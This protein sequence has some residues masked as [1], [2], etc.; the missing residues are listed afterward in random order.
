MKQK[1]LIIIDVSFTERDYKRFGIDILK[2]KFDVF[3]FD[4]TKNFIKKSATHKY[5]QNPYKFSGYYD[6]KNISTFVE[7]LDKHKFSNCI[8]YVSNKPLQHKLIDILK[9]NKIPIIKIQHGLFVEPGDLRTFIQKFHI[10]ILKFTNKKMFLVFIKNQIINLRKRF[11]RKVPNIFYDKVIV[12]GKVGLKRPAISLNT[13]VI[14]AHTYDYDNYLDIK[15][16]PKSGI[17]KP[18]AV[19]ID[20]YLPL[21]PD[22][23]I[24]FGV[25]PR[26][27]VE[28]YYPALNNFF[29]IFEK[30]YNMNIIVS[31]HPKSDY[32]SNPK[33]LYGRKFVRNKTISLIRDCEVVFSHCSAAISYAILLKKPI[34][35]LLSNEYI[36]SF[37][38]Y[39]PA[40]LAKKLNSLYFNID[41]KNNNSKIKNINLFKVDNKKYK[42]YK[43]DY[44]KYPSSI[45]KKFWKIFNE[46]I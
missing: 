39:T 45:N 22:A 40:V 11:I 41:D 30:E 21:H 33:F 31:A 43:D 12:T 15:K 17:K 2:K 8:D 19:F 1:I 5:F 42:I 16:I 9:I 44:I 10:L 3:V 18:Y 29:N 20:Q 14:Y 36:K 6:I 7:L 46:K 37:D 38:N 26:V 13:E 34:I 32:E 28:K 4:F 23:T 27:T 25:S 24:Y 35:F